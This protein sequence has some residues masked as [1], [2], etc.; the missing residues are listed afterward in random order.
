MGLCHE[1]NGD[2]DLALACYLEAL[3]GF[4][5]TDQKQKQVQNVANIGLMYKNMEDYANALKYFERA[6]EEEELE[7]REYYDEDIQLCRERLE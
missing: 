5:G 3:E 7:F 2:Y 4:E 1:G 6:R